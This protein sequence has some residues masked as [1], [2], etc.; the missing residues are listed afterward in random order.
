MED[1]TQAPLLTF[2]CPSRW[3]PE[4]EHCIPIPGLTRCFWGTANIRP[5]PCYWFFLPNLFAN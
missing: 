3:H 4:D 2:F 5:I 1:T